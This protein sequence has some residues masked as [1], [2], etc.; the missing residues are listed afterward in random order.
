M[1][2][3]TTITAASVAGRVHDVESRPLRA[4]DCRVLPVV[5]I[6]G[7]GK[8]DIID[9]YHRLAGM[10]AAGETI[11]PVVDCDDAK[12]CGIAANAENPESQAEALAAIYASVA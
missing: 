2:R 12:L 1:A 8:V 4:S 7:S 5:M 10:I 11:L 9:G 3:R 6:D